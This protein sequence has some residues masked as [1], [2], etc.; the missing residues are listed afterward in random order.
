[1]TCLVGFSSAASSLDSEPLHQLPAESGKISYFSSK[2]LGS[3]EEAAWGELL[4]LDC[5]NDD[6][7]KYWY[8]AMRWPYAGLEG[9]ELYQVKD[10]WH[11]KKILVTNPA[12]GKQVVLAAKDWGP[13]IN[14]GRV[15]DVSKTSIDALGASTD[16][17]VNIEFADQTADLGVYAGESGSSTSG[18]YEDLEEVE[19]DVSEQSEDSVQD[20]RIKNAIKWAESQIGST[21]YYHDGYSW[22]LDFVEDA[23]ESGANSAPKRNWGNAKQ[24][25]IGLN[26]ASNKGVPPIGTFVFYEYKTYGHVGLSVGNGEVIH[27]P[28]KEPIRK[29]YYTNVLGLNYIGWAYPPVNPP[30]KIKHVW[31]FNTPGDLEGW[32]P[33]NM[34]GDKY[35]VEDGRLFLDPSESDPWIE[36]ND[37]YLDAS[38]AKFVNLGMSSNCPDNTG[39]VYFKTSE[40]PSYGEDKKVKF[41]VM[42][43]PGWY[44]YSVSMADNS[45]WE[46]TVTGIRIDPANNGI[47]G[48]NEDTVGF[49]YIRVEATGSGESEKGIIPSAVKVG[50]VLEKNPV[51]EEKVEEEVEGIMGKVNEF[52]EMLMGLFGGFI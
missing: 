18:D 48:T 1:M 11:N 43:G 9:A 41:T 49:E 10:W 40:S 16:D 30:L 17:V 21:A 3:C 20:I 31:E 37:L 38:T 50:E 45:L 34:E 52:I 2:D 23:Y 44:E 19:I 12:N 39:T 13:N 42:T 6:A 7:T 51:S 32:E 28:G 8:V 47:T 33:H 25:A 15:I 26:A 36:I 14:T 4:G 35:S 22:C 29:D 46:G 24:A 5:G 27:V